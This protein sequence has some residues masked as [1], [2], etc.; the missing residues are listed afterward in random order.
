MCPLYVFVQPEQ[1]CN[2]TETLKTLA[3]MQR[4]RTLLE[5][6]IDKNGFPYQIAARNERKTK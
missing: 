3:A 6:C 2:N 1:L 4:G 5:I